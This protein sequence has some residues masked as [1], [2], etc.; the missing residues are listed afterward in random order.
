MA[1]D[2]QMS[3][4]AITVLT[5]PLASMNSSCRSNIG[6]RWISLK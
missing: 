6:N 1:G 2:E 4:I 3:G 5:P